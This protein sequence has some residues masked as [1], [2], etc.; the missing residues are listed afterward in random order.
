MRVGLG[1]DRQRAHGGF[2][3]RR[4]W[5]RRCS[6]ADGECLT[7]HRVGEKGVLGSRTDGDGPDA[8]ALANRQSLLDPTRSMRPINRPVEAITNSGRK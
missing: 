3:R 5:A 6:K 7:C 4:S 1:C 2:R 8:H